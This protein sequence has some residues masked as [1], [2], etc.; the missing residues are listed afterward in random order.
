MRRN[1]ERLGCAYDRYCCRAALV[2]ATVVAVLCFLALIAIPFA[3]RGGPDTTYNLQRMQAR[4]ETPNAQIQLKNHGP[5]ES[6]GGGLKDYTYETI[7]IRATGECRY[8][9]HPALHQKVVTFCHDPEAPGGL[10]FYQAG[11]R[12]CHA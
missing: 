8:V 9:E 5:L 3:L 10:V 2:K 7:C 11:N 1:N 4:E 12:Y 6:V